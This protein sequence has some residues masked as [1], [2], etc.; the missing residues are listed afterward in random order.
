MTPCV[1]PDRELPVHSKIAKLLVRTACALTAALP[2]VAC[3]ASG[4]TRGADLYAN[5]HTVEAEEVF[6]H[7]E[8]RLADYDV[9]ERAR[10]GLY[11]GAA[12][13]SLGDVPRATHW[14]DYAKRHSGALGEEER[15]MLTH[16]LGVAA[17]EKM[18]ARRLAGTPVPVPPSAHAE[19]EHATTTY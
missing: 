13:L 17:R 11:R 15:T 12:L 16:A 1:G 7:T 3:G 8:A 4:V 5:G 19:A 18:D 9:E 6:E 14:L 10:Y 2:L